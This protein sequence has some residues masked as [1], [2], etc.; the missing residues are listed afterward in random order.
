MGID[1]DA[2][3]LKRGVLDLAYRQFS[4]RQLHGYGTGIT[5]DQ[6]EG[7]WLLERFIKD[8]GELLEQFA[9]F[10]VLE[11]ERRL[12]EAK[13]TVWWMAQ[14]IRDPAVSGRSGVCETSSEACAVF[15]YIQWIAAEQLKDAGACGPSIHACWVVL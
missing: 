15:Q 3:C 5:A 14:A 1:Y 4:Q 9:V 12:V 2:V 8:E 10:Q 11:E 6:R 7:N 13:P